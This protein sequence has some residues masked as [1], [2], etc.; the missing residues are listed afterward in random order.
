MGGAMALAGFSIAQAEEY[1]TRPISVAAC[2]PAGGGVDRNLR[3]I[4]RVAQRYLGQP[5]LLQYKT[6]GSGTVAMQYLK[7]ADPD[8][9]ELVICDNGGSI[10]APVA[11]GIDLGLDDITPIAQVSFVPWVLTARAEAGY[12]TLEDFIKAA[13]ESDTP[14]SLEISGLATSDHFGFLLLL[15]AAGLSPDMFKWNP[16]GGGGP[17]MRA[18]LANEGDLML[19]DAGEIAGYVRAG[20]LVPLAVAAAER[21]P[22]LP[23][24]P[25]MKELGYDV[26]AGMSTV[27][28]AP[29]GLTPERLEILRA[30]MRQIKEDPEVINALELTSQ[31]PATFIVDGYE[32]L[33]ERDFND[34]E[35]LLKEVIGR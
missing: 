28:Y 6:G 33:W 12:E 16:H 25:T 21:L 26:T 30:A 35:E 3:I 17:K 2:Y 32:A 31:D 27:L 14:T 23:D 24:V 8:G 7:A 20:T 10:I 11:Q 18:M 15:K 19:E 5:L 29:G 22:Q 1:P 4:E 34:A 9:Y 13:R